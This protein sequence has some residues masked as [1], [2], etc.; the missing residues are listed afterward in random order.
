MS[1]KKK[2]EQAGAEAQVET[3]AA[4]L[5]EEGAVVADD[6]IPDVE[7]EA[8]AADVVEPADGLAEGEILDESTAEWTVV[9]DPLEDAAI[10]HNGAPVRLD[11]SK[12]TDSEAALRAY[13][14]ETRLMTDEA[15][16]VEGELRE[17]VEITNEEHKR[18]KKA[19]E[20]HE[21]T[22]RE[23]RAERRGNRGKPQQPQL[24]PDPAQY[25]K[26]ATGEDSKDYDVAPDSWKSTEAPVTCQP[27]TK[28]DDAQ[29][30]TFRSVTLREMV[31][32]DGL[33]AK[34][35]EIL[36]NNG[37]DT[38]GK[39]VD[40]TTPTASG[41]CPSLADFTGFGPKKV[42]QWGDA[43]ERF[44]KRWPGVLR[45][46]SR[47]ADPGPGV[48]GGGGES[49]S[50]GEL[51]IPI[52]EIA[53]GHREEPPVEQYDDGGDTASEGEGETGVVEEEDDFGFKGPA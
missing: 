30:E 24:Y 9:G 40:F 39:V 16:R 21:E 44:W 3:A 32:L 12:A 45:E 41:W 15:D 36:E 31:A 2:A 53:G 34:A 42:E 46:R 11:Y 35:A 17:R 50:A 37:L 25:A 5:A 26:H 22:S 6:P 28:D 52:G 4:P 47:A 8:R 18:A 14:E 23:M 19:L 1:K 49:G 27:E 48:E 51:D 7:V 10:M 43:C 13:D 38:L 33:P 20:V 29:D